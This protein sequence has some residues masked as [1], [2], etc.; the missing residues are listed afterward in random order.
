MKEIKWIYILI[1]LLFMLSWILL[2]FQELRK[3]IL[4]IVIE[5]DKILIKNFIGYRK[6]F[7]FDEFEGFQ[8]STEKSKSGT[9]EVLSLVK[10]GRRVIQIS[11]FNFRN[12]DELK[13]AIKLQT[14]DLGFV[15]LNFIKRIKDI[16]K[17]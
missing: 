13:N 10:N 2:F 9:Y 3:R 5:N 1:A 4:V 14:K 7:K 12:Y 17:S 11:E 15:Q 8:T 16:F 6:D